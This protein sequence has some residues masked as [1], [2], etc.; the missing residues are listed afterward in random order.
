LGIIYAILAIGVLGFVVWAHHIFTVGIDADTRAYFTSATPYPPSGRG[1]P[2]PPSNSSGITPRPGSAL[3]AVSGPPQ[4]YGYSDFRAKQ[5]ASKQDY[6]QMKQ[7]MKIEKD[8]AKQKATHD[9]QIAKLQRMQPAELQYKITQLHMKMSDEKA[10]FKLQQAKHNE[11]I[12][13]IEQDISLYEGIC[14]EKQRE[15][16]YG[17]PGGGYGG[18]PSGRG[19]GDQPSRGA[20]PPPSKGPLPA[21]WEEHFDPQ[22]T[23]YYHNKATGSTTWTRPAPASGAPSGVPPPPPPPGSSMRKY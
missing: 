1:V 15:Q 6:Q 22:G 13:E 5:Q 12:M 2:P 8:Q 17:P 4:T 7:K 21:G 18:Q 16:Q 23:P 19:Y 3:E 9:K 20:V 14:G 11:R 10:D